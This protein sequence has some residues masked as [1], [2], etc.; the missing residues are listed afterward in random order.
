MKFFTRW[1]RGAKAPMLDCDTVMRQLWD[2]LDGEL[3]PERTEAIR[4]HIAMCSRCHP[5]TEFERAFLA[6][7]NR[8]R[9]EH[10]HVEKLRVQ[11]LESLRTQGFAP[12]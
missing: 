9:R 5:Q 1:F 4:N 3:T 10:S 11:L 2:Y 6:A 12:Q 7:V 8:S